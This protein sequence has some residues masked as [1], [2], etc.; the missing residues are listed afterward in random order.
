[1]LDL[2]QGS[3]SGAGTGALDTRGEVKEERGSGGQGHTPEIPRGCCREVCTVS[4]LSDILS[5]PHSWTPPH[6][7][8]WLSSPKHCAGCWACRLL[9]RS[10]W[11]GGRPH[12]AIWAVMPIETE[13]W[14]ATQGDGQS[15]APTGALLAEREQFILSDLNAI[16]TLEF[17]TMRGDTFG[18]VHNVS[19]LSNPRTAS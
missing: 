17:M 3:G 16:K 12:G 9:S 14:G 10:S 15:L 2:G 13:C 18:L 5:P 19:L 1:M 4:D 6:P 8:T 7:P 11:P